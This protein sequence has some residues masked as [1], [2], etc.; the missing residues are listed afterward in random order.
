M[1]LGEHIDEA[2]AE[3]ERFETRKT[4]GDQPFTARIMGPDKP[5]SYDEEPLE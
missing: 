1:T 4:L 2:T 5:D 3:I